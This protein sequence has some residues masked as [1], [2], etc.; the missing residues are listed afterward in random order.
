MPADRNNQKKIQCWV[1]IELWD[2]VEF[3]GYSSITIAVTDAFSKLV[4]NPTS[5]NGESQEIPTLKARLDELEKHN[6]TLKTYNETL[7][8]ELE[9]AGQDKEAIQNL[10]NNYMLQMQTLINQRAIDMP[11]EKKSFLAIVTR[12]NNATAQ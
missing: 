3:L 10:Y 12:L 1:P 5:S 6:E 11:G 9:K 7:K 8:A 4:E 2:K